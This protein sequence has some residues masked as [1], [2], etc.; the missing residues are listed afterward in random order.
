MKILLLNDNPVVT[1]LVTLSAQKLEDE[2]EA[3]ASVENVQEGASY[4]LLIVDDNLYIPEDIQRLQ[5]KVECKKM[6]FIRSKET[7]TPKE[8]DESLTKPFLPTDLVDIL[9]KIR[10]SIVNESAVLK[11]ED[12]IEETDDLLEGEKEH[13]DEFEEILPDDLTEFDLGEDLNLEDELDMLEELPSDESISI[14][15]EIA[16]DGGIL[17]EEELKEVQDLLKEEENVSFDDDLSD[18]EHFEIEAGDSVGLPMK[19]VSNEEQELRESETETAS[20]MEEDKMKEDDDVELD[21]LLDELEDEPEIDEAADSD[22]WSEE[23]E[24]M[25][26][27]KNADLS[28]ESISQ[29]EIVTEE[30]V[31]TLLEKS[32]LEFNDNDEFDDE[33]LEKLLEEESNKEAEDKEETPTELSEEIQERQNRMEEE[34]KAAY[35]TKSVEG[36]S[37]VEEIEKEIEAAE[38][39]M[40][41]QELEGEL[42]SGFLDDLNLLDEKSLKEALGEEM[43]DEDSS[44]K[45]QNEQEEIEEEKRTQEALQELP[46]PT[47]NKRDKAAEKGSV[48]VLKKLLEVLSD[49]DIAA[50]LD[51]KKIT[52]NITI[53]DE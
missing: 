43:A 22:T 2:V 37:S 32:G 34:K 23:K 8:F 17:D 48:E 6:L 26:D 47:S 12:E 33:N 15:E 52:I 1:K 41:P 27:E 24:E 14:D 39:N 51:G 10:K 9:T 25:E 31:E 7:E 29:D 44:K 53:G 49:A 5:S 46:E 50:S 45:Y 13:P 4:D 16:E 40:S 36:V 35:E 11:E 30:D 3:V 42:E 28:K 19:S 18:D 21:V 20:D 38:A